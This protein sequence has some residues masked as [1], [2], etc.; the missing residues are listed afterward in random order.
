L[1]KITGAP[2]NDGRIEEIVETRSE[3]ST[4]PGMMGRPFNVI[5]PG[6]TLNTCMKKLSS[7]PA[8]VECNSISEQEELD[9][10]IPGRD[11]LQDAVQTQPEDVVQDGANAMQNQIFQEN[12]NDPIEKWPLEKT[13]CYTC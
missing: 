12:A 4:G 10:A 7:A 1:Q 6:D 8:H 13:C 5:E 2:E 11:K 3:N 9:A